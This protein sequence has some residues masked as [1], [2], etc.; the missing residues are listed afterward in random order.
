[1]GPITHAIGMKVSELAA[2]VLQKHSLC[3][4]N[5]LQD[6]DKQVSSLM[7]ATSKSSVVE[8]TDLAEVAIDSEANI[9]SDDEI[10][11]FNSLSSGFGVNLLEFLVPFNVNFVMIV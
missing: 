2:M 11:F 1:M 6:L 9:F 7:Y 10:E 4:S 8:G 5:V 3:R